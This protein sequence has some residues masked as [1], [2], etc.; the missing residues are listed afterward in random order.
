MW[1]K[2]KDR[3]VFPNFMAFSL[4]AGC[5][6]CQAEWLKLQQKACSLSETDF[7]TTTATGKVKRESQKE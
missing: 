7:G 3:D 1:D 4:V 2:G 5:G 6:Q